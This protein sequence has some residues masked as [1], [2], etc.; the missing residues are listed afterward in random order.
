MPEMEPATPIIRWA[1]F[2][3]HD[4]VCQLDLCMSNIGDRGEKVVVAYQPTGSTLSTPINWPGPLMSAEQRLKELCDAGL[5]CWSGRRLE[6]IAP[7]A[8]VRGESTVAELI[9]HDRR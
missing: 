5:V 4:A 3:Y 6:P 1:L 8:K 9:I 2:S 7:L